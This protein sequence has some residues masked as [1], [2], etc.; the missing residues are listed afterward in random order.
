MKPQISIQKWLQSISAAAMQSIIIAFLLLILSWHSAIIAQNP[1]I[2][3]NAIPVAEFYN[4]CYQGSCGPFEGFATELGVNKGNTVRFKISGPNGL[5]YSIK[6]YR[7]G[8]Y[9]GKGARLQATL[10]GPYVGTNQSGLTT[11]D[12]NT[13]MVSCNL[14]AESAHWDIPS[15]AVSG[16]YQAV[17]L[18]ENGGTSYII[19]I[20]RDDDYHSAMLYKTADANWHA[21]NRWGGRSFYDGGISGNLGTYNHAVKLSYQRP[22]DGVTSQ[23]FFGQ[24]ELPLIRW[25]EKNGYDVSYTTQLDMSRDANLSITPAQHKILISA[26]HDE[27]WSAENRTVWERARNNGVN[28]AFFS[29][30]EIYWKTRWEDNMKTLVCFKEGTLGENNCGGACDPSEL[31]TGLW[32]DGCGPVYA[33]P[34]NYGGAIDACNPENQLGGQISWV[35]GVGTMTVSDTYKDMRFWKHTAIANLQPGQSISLSPN[36]L[37]SEWDQ[38]QYASYYPPRRILLSTTQ[39]SGLIHNLSLYRHTSGALVFAAGTIRWSWGLYAQHEDGPSVEDLNMK[40]AMVNLFAYM[41]VPPV[42][43]QL[44][45]GLF[46]ETGATSSIPPVSVITSP[47]NGAAL[48]SSTVTITGTASAPAD[49]VLFGIEISVDGGT[50][51]NQASGAANWSF[52]WNPPAPGTY[53]IKVRGWDDLGNVEV[54]GTV[55]VEFS[56]CISVTFNGPSVFSV[57]LPNQPGAD[58][59]NGTGLPLEVGMRFRSNA[60]GY[61]ISLKYY[62]IAGTTGVHTG[63]LWANGGS[64]PLVSATFINE[65]LSGWQ[66]VTLPTPYPITANTLYVVSYF[67][68]SGQYPSSSLNY[69]TSDVVNGPLTAPAANN[70]LY[71]YNATSAY[72]S[73]STLTN[74]WVDVT[75]ST[76]LGADEIP[77]SVLTISPINNAPGVPI[78]IHPSVAFSEPLDPETV[79]SNTFILTGP[80]STPVTGTVSYN[81]GINTA[82]FTPS[83]PLA[84]NTAYTAKVIGG[85]NDPRIKDVAGNAL[86]AD[87]TW[88]FTTEIYVQPSITVHPV[89]QSTCSGSSVSFSSA[90]TGNPT[91]T[92][93]WQVST[94]GG[95]T[96]SDISGATT[97]P[98]TF[99]SAIGDND[100]QY[101][102]FWTNGEWSGTSD[103]AILTVV[104]GISGSINAVNPNIC[105][106][107]PFQL[108]LINATGLQPFTLIVN[109]KT[110]SGVGNNTTFATIPSADEGIWPSTATPSNADETSSTPYELG[111]KFKPI[112][113]GYIKGI[114]FYKGPNNTGTHIGRLWTATG[115]SQLASATFTNETA[116][117]WQQVLFSSPVVVTANT[118]YV[119]SYSV[120]AGHFSQSLSYFNTNT[121]VI[122]A[123]GLVQTLPSTGN[124]VFNGSIGQFPNTVPPLFT[125]YWVDVV[126]AYSVNNNTIT[127]NLTSLADNGTCTITGNPVS[128][129]GI[130]VHNTNAPTVNSPVFYNQ[131]DAASPLSATGTN[132]LWYTTPTGGTGSP[133]APTPSTSGTGTTSYYVSQTENGCESP[134]AQI[135]VI[136]TGPAGW[137]DVNWNY[138]RPIVLTNSCGTALTDY[139]F[140]V[141]LNNTFDFTQ[142]KTDGSDIRLLTLTDQHPFRIGSKLG[143]PVICRQESG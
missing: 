15:T 19:F 125:N 137:Y 143:T 33:N 38:Y 44:E 99:T 114:R 65:T 8:Y 6:I 54:P 48:S 37:G 102:A 115:S 23:N 3:E 27:Y 25:M 11:D 120:P 1:I 16:L 75:F 20:V 140:L 131:G 138:R 122:S 57:F 130:T 72:P 22:F 12:L 58:P 126:F 73:A 141:S 94:D 34:A 24:A 133:G 14:W 9:Q 35:N 142:T 112:A 113:D 110:Y 106:G 21:Y 60:D 78:T 132:L 89:S 129:V 134:R 55:P 92:L 4:D 47:V 117:G 105:P 53:T 87:Y 82:T 67:S 111:V 13:G 97:S 41:G 98:Y 46:Y 62:K 70:G 90:A 49:A 76:T 109:G 5:V 80:G 45:N 101:H 103:P 17:I 95:T 61:I 59:Q 68:P 36:S 116:T 123:N 18:D 31:W 71:I 84:F 63:N 108:Q 66:T 136:V 124:G 91:P 42:A 93:Q 88:T 100:K 74:Y 69:F 26:G 56:N 79:N 30:N 86:P 43:G 96:W 52:S 104:T 77:P 39:S 107:D 83:W 128:T 7:L 28:L 119:A 135:D 40:Q 10:P 51:W 64:T 127:N 118:T 121:P 32:R 81:S 50:T 29:G 139:Q 85:A 2:V